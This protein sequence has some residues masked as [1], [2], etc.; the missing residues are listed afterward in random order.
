MSAST[1][2]AQAGLC[3]DAITPIGPCRV[4]SELATAF[5]D[6]LSVQGEMQRRTAYHTAILVDRSCSPAPAVLRG[7]DNAHSRQIV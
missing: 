4:N 7:N 6:L 3:A 1:V 2:D 5:V